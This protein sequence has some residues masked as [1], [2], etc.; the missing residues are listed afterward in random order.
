MENGE[1]T[2]EVT[3]KSG[4]TTAALVLGII[5]IVWFPGGIIG[6]VGLILA[7]I[8]LAKKKQPKAKAVWGLILSIVGPL[9]GFITA[10]IIAIVL[11]LTGSIATVFA[12]LGL[13]SLANQIDDYGIDHAWDGD[14]YDYTGYGDYDDDDDY[15]YTGL[16]GMD[17]WYEQYGDLYSDLLGDDWYDNYNTGYDD[18]DYDTYGDYDYDDD[19]YNSDDDDYDDS[20]DS[21]RDLS[22]YDQY[23]DTYGAEMTDEEWDEFIEAYDAIYG[24]TEYEDWL[25]GGL[26]Q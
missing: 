19:E 22:K 23:R 15:N 4:L 12:S 7:I 24:G 21:D 26:T 10:I 9:L 3:K 25:F 1:M 17:D 16:T 13:N 8:A 14:G 11:A 2:N 6:L 5:S 20:D 18:D